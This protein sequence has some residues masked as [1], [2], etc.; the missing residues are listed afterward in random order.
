M[1]WYCVLKLG[2]DH[3]D[4]RSPTIEDVSLP[5]AA[6]SQFVLSHFTAGIT[7]IADVICQVGVGEEPGEEG[8]TTEKFENLVAVT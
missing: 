8:G 1:W 2:D 3:P 5:N 4:M 7:S 6:L